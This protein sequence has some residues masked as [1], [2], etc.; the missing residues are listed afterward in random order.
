MQNDDFANVNGAGESGR[1]IDQLEDPL[2]R[3]VHRPIFHS[4]ILTGFFRSRHL[5]RLRYIKNEESADF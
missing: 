2:F 3:S 4:S 1:P 5:S